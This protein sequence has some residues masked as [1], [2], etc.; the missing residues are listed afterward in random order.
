MTLDRYIARQYL[1]N[2]LVLLVLLFSFVVMVDVSI[3]LTRFFRSAGAMVGREAESSGLRQAII[4]VL[5]V[6]NLW[7]PRLLQLF[8]YIIGLVL[9]G[10]MGFTFTQL[11]R[12]REVVAMLA[13]GVSLWRAARPILLVAALMVTLQVLNQ[14]IVIPRIAPLL[15]RDTS[16]AADQQVDAFPVRLTIDGSGR[17]IAAARFRPSTATME[18]V[19]IW[20]RNPQ[21]R[22]TRRISAESAVFEP[23]PGGTGGSWRLINPKVASFAMTR[24]GSPT[25]AEPPPTRLDTDL[26]PTT[27]LVGQ[28]TT[29]SQSLS[30][31]QIAHVL[32]TPGVR[33][34]VAETLTRV[35]LGRVSGI[36]CTMLALVICLPFFLTR[37]PRNMV[38]Q[39]LKCAPIAI[40]TT[41]GAVLGTAMPIPGL[42]AAAAVFIPVVILAPLAIAAATAVK[43]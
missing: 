2:I 21:G 15:T 23:G 1:L 12:Q 32:G 42:P 33:P 9:I 4:T 31:R 8:N 43:T 20:E 6:A 36:L 34:E 11:V 40:I 16:S 38:V 14:E 22:A 29:F 7:W 18:N 30:W 41:L 24:S 37:E 39:S 25:E 3:N 17:L 19:H 10:A 5:L 26:S 35:G 13:G 28:F 27:L